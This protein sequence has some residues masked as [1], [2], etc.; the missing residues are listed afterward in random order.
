MRMADENNSNLTWERSSVLKWGLFGLTIVVA[1]IFGA[2]LT[3]I[4]TLDSALSEQVAARNIEVYRQLLT[5]NC[6]SPEQ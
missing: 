1:A 4:K 3:W 6:P 5:E 2:G